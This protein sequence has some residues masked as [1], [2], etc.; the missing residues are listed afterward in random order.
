MWKYI[1]TGS[2]PGRINMS[3]DEELVRLVAGGTFQGAV[4]VYGWEPPCISLGFHQ[5]LGHVDARKCQEAGIEIVRRPTG[6]RAVLHWDEATYSVVKTVNGESL[7]E[8]Y[9]SIGMALVNALRRLHPDISLARCDLRELPSDR[10]TSSVPCYSSIARY[11]IQ[12][13]GRKIVGS[14]QRRYSFP[15]ETGVPNEVVLQH[16]SILLGPSHLRI[17]E[18]LNAKNSDSVLQMKMELAERSTDLST[19]LGRSVAF[20]EI[21]EC[22][23]DGFESEW[24]IEF[25]SRDIQTDSITE[26]LTAL[27]PQEH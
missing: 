7:S 22:L 5:D 23:K 14:A 19:I 26:L 20:N 10:P 12:Y 25:N 17:V 1:N 15:S 24:G 2:S 8:I 9:C 11:E 21:A 6:G 27:S 13:R 18:F 16:G 4:R 3:F